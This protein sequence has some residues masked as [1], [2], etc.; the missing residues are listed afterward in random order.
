MKE[1]FNINNNSE[2]FH[3]EKRKFLY[4]K[5]EEKVESILELR[6]FAKNHEKDN[7]D[8]LEVNIKLKQQKLLDDYFSRGFI[9]MEEKGKL[10]SFPEIIREGHELSQL[11]MKEEAKANLTSSNEQEYNQKRAQFEKEEK[12][13]DEIMAE[14]VA[15]ES[16]IDLRWTPFIAHHPC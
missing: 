5:L 11:L 13:L 15:E 4:E 14:Y 10:A 6:S 2:D 12:R 16:N 3:L 1:N 9:T 7:L 8:D